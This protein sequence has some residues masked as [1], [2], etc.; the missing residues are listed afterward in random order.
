MKTNRVLCIVLSCLMLL[1]ACGKI[2]SHKEED[3]KPKVEAKIE[4]CQLEQYID[5]FDDLVI[6]I[7]EEFKSTG[8]VITDSQTQVS[9]NDTSLST[10][11]HFGNGTWYLDVDGIIVQVDCVDKQAKRFNYYDGRMNQHVYIVDSKQENGIVYSPEEGGF[12]VKSSEEGSDIPDPK[13]RETIPESNTTSEELS[14]WYIDDLSSEEIVEICINLC[15]YEEPRQNETFD[16]FVSRINLENTHMK[17][18]FRDYDS[19]MW[20]SFSEQTDESTKDR[21]TNAKVNLYYK[22][23]MDNSIT[24]M[25]PPQSSISMRI[26]SYEKAVEIYNAFKSR[27]EQFD[28]IVEFKEDMVWGTGILIN[29]AYNSPKYVRQLDYN[30]CKVGVVLENNEGNYV[31]RVWWTPLSKTIE[32]KETEYQEGCIFPNSS[33]E[34]IS[35]E[36]IKKLTDEQLRYAINEIWARHGYI[37][38]TP[39]ILKYYRQFD[40]YEEKVPSSEWNK[41]GQN[42]YL[43]DIEKTNI[44]RMTKE[45]DSRGYQIGG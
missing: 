30:S 4:N 2:H 11:K 16:E 23:E 31:I 18:I 14:T 34:E 32:E 26:Y 41:N 38:S 42:Y 43:N 33:T 10:L 3:N 7:Q 1:S 20:F 45:R 39:E 44:N 13:P 22:R 17:R 28:E 37:F 12:V 27:F 36:E 19:S 5:N 40:W 21:I 35:E 9:N 29:E 6:Q 8:L 24:K 25:N 15:N